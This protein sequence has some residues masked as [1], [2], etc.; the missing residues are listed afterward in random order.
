[1]TNLAHRSTPIAG[2]K[3]DGERFISIYAGKLFDSHSQQLLPCRVVSISRDSGLVADVQEW[4]PED[5]RGLDFANDASLVDLREATVLPG[6]VDTHVHMFLH[7]YAEVSWEN[8]LTQ[9]SLVERTVRATVHAK[10]TLMAG[11]TT[12]RDLGTEG[13]E[14]ADVQLRKCMSGPNALIPG[15]R[16]FC[17]N[18]AI[19]CSG[20]YGPKS[21][22]H[23]HQ[24]GVDCVTGAEFVDGEV[25]CVKAVRKQIGAGADWVKVTSL[26]TH[27]LPDYR[28][29]TRM[30]DVSTATPAKA[31]RTFS[32]PELAALITTARGL[33]VRVA[34]HVQT[35]RLDLLPENGGVDTLEHGADLPADLLPA[36]AASRVIWV[37][38]LSVF[39]TIDTARAPGGLWDRAAKNFQAALK[40]GVTRIACGGDTGPFPHGENA[41]EMKL[42][43]RL[44]APWRSVL[45]WATLGG[46]EAVRSVEWE[47]ALGEA[48]IARLGEMREDARVVGDNEVP[49]GALRR[50]F[51]ADIVATV[52]D[53]E[54]NFARAVDKDNIVFVMKGGKIV[55]MNGS[56]LV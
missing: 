46:W 38:T 37:P 50:G 41:L 30:A 33:G 25:E 19:I 26:S 51:A 9:E 52:G 18:R 4:G 22:L 24:D 6:F 14:D 20:Y 55:K 40:A 42:M 8:Q 48:R 54:T 23:Y 43:V 7:P 13:A 45:R 17:A 49:F 39:Y 32:P 11:Y 44:G 34:A 27:T 29:R 21:Q 31:V 3:D 35:W 12:V 56:P 53:L 16:Y 1:M 47:G 36:V 2:S 15:P 10:R 28:P 5:V